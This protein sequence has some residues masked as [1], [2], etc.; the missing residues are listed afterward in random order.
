MFLG[1][2]IVLPPMRGR[3]LVKN[4]V[5]SAVDAPII[6]VGCPIRDS[7]RQIIGGLFV[8]IESG[9]EFTELLDLGRAGPRGDTYAFGPQGQL[10]SASRYESDLPAMGLTNSAEQGASVLHV[11][12]RDPGVNLATNRANARPISQRPLTKMAAAAIAGGDGI[13]LDGYR[14]YRGVDVVGAWKWLKPYDFG[15]ATEIEFD[16]AYAPLNYVRRALWTLFSLLVL[17]AAIAFASSLS[18]F[19]LRREIALRSSLAS[20]RSKS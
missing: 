3:T 7:N 14:D 4:E 17:F 12:V 10:L 1:Q 19:R 18:V 20:T 15:I 9:K 2:D 16:D 6:L 11:E 5:P 8:S 13:D